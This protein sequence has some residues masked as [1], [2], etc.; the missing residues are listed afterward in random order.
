MLL[1]IVIPLILPVRQFLLTALMRPF[2]WIEAAINA[3]A[4]LD[5]CY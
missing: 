1:L 3:L 4:P 5:L 2:R